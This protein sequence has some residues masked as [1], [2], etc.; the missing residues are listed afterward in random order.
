MPR[1]VTGYVLGFY[2]LFAI[3]GRFVEAMGAVQCSCGPNCWCKR[4]ILRTFRW[5]FPFRHRVARLSL[6]TRSM[7]ATGGGEADPA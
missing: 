1:R 5:A 4:P 2:L 3:I 6:M 7:R